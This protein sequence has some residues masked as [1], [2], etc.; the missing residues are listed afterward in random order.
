MTRNKPNKPITGHIGIGVGTNSRGG[1]GTGVIITGVD[2]GG[3]CVLTTVGWRVTVLVIVGVIVLVAVE[4]AAIGI[5]IIPVSRPHNLWVSQTSASTGYSPTGARVPSSKRRS[6]NTDSGIPSKSNFKTIILESLC[7]SRIVTLTL[8]IGYVFCFTFRTPASHIHQR[9]VRETTGG[10]TVWVGWEVE[11]GSEVRVNTA[12]DVGDGGSEV[13]VGLNVAV[14]GAIRVVV[15]V[16][17]N[18]GME[19]RVGV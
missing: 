18:A 5:K 9:S 8:L 13:R 10:K 12:V 1:L 6:Q 19:V 16:L 7:G 15:G 14:E 11:V 3:I 4:V 17:V 2:V